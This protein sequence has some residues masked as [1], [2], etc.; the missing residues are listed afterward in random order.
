MANPF[1]PFYGFVKLEGPLHMRLHIKRQWVTRSNGMA[2]VVA[3][4]IA[5]WSNMTE[6]SCEGPAE[7]SR[8]EHCWPFIQPYT[9]P[10]SQQARP[11]DG[12][13]RWPEP[14]EVARF[15]KPPPNVSIAKDDAGPGEGGAPLIVDLGP[16]AL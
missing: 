9:W 4:V 16:D 1:L 3:L 8:I 7:L 5:V 6:R 15:R 11:P 14:Q 2:S 10:R 12:G 13:R